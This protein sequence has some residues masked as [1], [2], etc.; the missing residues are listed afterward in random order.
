MCVSAAP[1]GPPRCVVGGRSSGAAEARRESEVM[2]AR[3]AEGAAARRLLGRATRSSVA[4]RCSPYGRTFATATLAGETGVPAG[5]LIVSVTACVCALM[6]EMVPVSGVIPPL[7]TYARAP[8]GVKP[9]PAG[10]LP[11]PIVPLTD[12]AA[13]ST[14]ETL[15]GG[16]A[17]KTNAPLGVTA[18]AE[19]E[20]LML[21]SSTT[22][23]V[24]AKMTNMRLDSASA[25]TLLSSGATAI[26]AGLSPI[27]IVATTDR[28]ARLTAET[29][30]AVLAT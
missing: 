1:A 11:T 30:D 23:F 8:S 9:T 13:V 24:G 18:S 2:A 10:K 26:S 20:P 4:D 14:T 15:P 29:E 3:A 28:V 17:T 6:T 7:P 27:G 21:I 19:S 16:F 5:K 22:L 25:Y 12:P